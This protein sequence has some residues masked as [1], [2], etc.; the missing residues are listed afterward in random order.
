MNDQLPEFGSAMR[1]SFCSRE[2][3]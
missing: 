3:P 1:F 2:W